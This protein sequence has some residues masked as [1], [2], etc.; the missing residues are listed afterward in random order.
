MWR[1]LIEII[2]ITTILFLR[3]API[4]Y[5]KR[6]KE[7]HQIQLEPEEIHNRFNK[8]INR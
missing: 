5:T 2:L 1:L 7:V 4:L 3:I 8:I 6:L